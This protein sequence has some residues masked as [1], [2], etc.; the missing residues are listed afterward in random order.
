MLRG[1][2]VFQCFPPAL[3]GWNC[4]YSASVSLE[5][6]RRRCDYVCKG[7]RILAGSLHILAE[8]SDLLIRALGCCDFMLKQVPYRR[9][10]WWRLLNSK[11]PGMPDQVVIY[12]LFTWKESPLKTSLQCCWSCVAWGQWL[13]TFVELKTSLVELN[14]KKFR[15]VELKTKRSLCL[16]Q[17]RTRKSSPVGGGRWRPF[18]MKNRSFEIRRNVDQI[19]ISRNPMIS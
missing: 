12:F 10:K 6:L 3:I 11:D 2:T 18:P 14:L 4:F 7:R 5:V 13:R 16:G 9:R 1:F 15:F 8:I 19:S 17:E